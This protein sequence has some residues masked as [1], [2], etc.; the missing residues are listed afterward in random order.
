MCSSI[1]VAVGMHENNTHNMGVDETYYIY[2][3]F[4]KLYKPIQ[5]IF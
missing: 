5:T 2:V 3:I 4:Y 1:N